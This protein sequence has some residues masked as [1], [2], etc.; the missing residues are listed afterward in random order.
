MPPNDVPRQV[1]R[2]LIAQHG[3]PLIEDP[4]RCE[5]LLRDLCGPHRRA[6]NV[7][8]AALKER[9]PADL[10]TSQDSVPKQMLLMQLTRRLCDDL[11]LAEDAARWAVDTWALAVGIEIEVPASY[12]EH[13]DEWSAWSSAAAAAPEVGE[14]VADL[15][16]RFAGRGITRARRKRAPRR[17]ERL[18]PLQSSFRMPGRMAEQIIEHCFGELPIMA[19]GL[20]GGI[21]GEATHL[22]PCSNSERSQDRFAVEAT[23]VDSVY[24]FC[25]KAGLSVVGVY[26][27]HIKDE[28]FPSQ[29]GIEL[30]N[31]PE[32]T[33]IIVSL[34]DMH[35]PQ[36]KAFSIIEGAVDEVAIELTEAPIRREGSPMEHYSVTDRG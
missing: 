20:L 33:A 21:N 26:W 35:T 17:A 10:L 19:C 12:K 13:S 29:S 7:L 16:R 1:L 24:S 27:C 2:Q 32:A 8:V 3:P 23:E 31:R 5:A 6:I 9:V 25:E 30:W 34:K 22:F 11:A 4:R 28:P 15:Q 36:M 14:S 18:R